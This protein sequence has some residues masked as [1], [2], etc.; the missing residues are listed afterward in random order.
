[1]STIFRHSKVESDRF[2]MNIYRY[3]GEKFDNQ[4][5]KKEI[6]RNNIDILILRVSSL[7]KNNHYKLSSLGFPFLHA[8]TL[9]YYSVLL[10]K[11]KNISLNNKDLTFKT[12]DVSNVHELKKMIPLIFRGYKNHYYSNP[13][14]EHK[15]INEGYIEWATSFKNDNSEN[16]LAW[17]VLDK[18]ITVAFATCSYRLDTNECEGVLYGV[19]PQH[20]GKGIYSDMIRFTKNY[21]ANKGFKK[22]WVSTQIQNYAV[23]KVW[24]K[25][26]FKIN[27]S[28]ETY[29]INSML[30]F[31][32]EIPKRFDF[33][34]ATNE[35][36][37]FSEF[38]GDVNPIH[39]NDRFAAKFGFSSRVVHGMI[40]Q[41]HLS[42]FFGT[43]YPGKGTIFM[44]NHNVFLAPNYPDKLYK[45]VVRVLD[46]NEK[47]G[48]IKVLAILAD[49][50]GA[51]C[52]L[53]YN[54]LLHKEK[55]L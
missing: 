34:V 41:S 42:K 38:S 11:N 50:E 53:S 19:L 21:F 10:K 28:L 47:N 35:I 20:T 26:G 5:L 44:E 27:K 46:S 55:R 29:H 6:I 15:K 4:T 45:C 13:A 43:I 16:R 51:I 48:V 24:Q 37:L 39:F 36:E 1:M 23:Q 25:E 22:M 18:G 17:L 7:T 2:N 9:V 54:T 32:I 12:V 52:T 8:D 31:S 3:S 14:F 30:K 40:F 49:E 33:S